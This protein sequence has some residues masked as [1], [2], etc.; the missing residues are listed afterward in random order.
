ML[1]GG[2]L[3]KYQVA[4]ER[5]KKREEFVAWRK[6]RKVQ[7]VLLVDVWCVFLVRCCCIV[8]KSI[9]VYTRCTSCSDSTWT[10]NEIACSFFMIRNRFVQ[11]VAMLMLLLDLTP[12]FPLK[13]TLPF[14]ARVIQNYERRK[15]KMKHFKIKW[16]VFSLFVDN[17]ADS[18]QIFLEHLFPSVP[19]PILIPS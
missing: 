15:M 18:W 2:C 3:C 6:K 8:Q 7:M 11:L 10:W 16:E 9:S 17:V 12:F 5:T 4:G 19:Q 14:P 1:Q 13:D